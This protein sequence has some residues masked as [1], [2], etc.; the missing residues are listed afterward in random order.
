MTNWV[1]T[2]SSS[3]QCYLPRINA[4]RPGGIAGFDCARPLLIHRLP[5]V[6]SIHPFPIKLLKIATT[7]LS[8][9][10]YTFVYHFLISFIFVIS[11]LVI[12]LHVAPLPFT[13][14][15][16]WFLTLPGRAFGPP[17]LSQRFATWASGSEIGEWDA[18]YQIGTPVL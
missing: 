18:G 1:A 6:S 3:Q 7:L 9:C 2:V 16:F 5:Y 17:N 15:Y 10:E 13:S 12:D 11:L 14:D 4:S 8:H